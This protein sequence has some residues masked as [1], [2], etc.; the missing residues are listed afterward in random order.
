[1]PGFKLSKITTKGGDIQAY[2]PIL[3]SIALTQAQREMIGG[4]TGCYA[5]ALEMTAR[6]LKFVL[7]PSPGD[8]KL[9]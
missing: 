3:L 6:E 8:E 9:E 1:M 4:A 2:E 7:G 5:E